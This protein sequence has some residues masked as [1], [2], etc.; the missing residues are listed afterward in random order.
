MPAET[1]QGRFR[2]E[3][4]KID[5]TPASAVSAGDVVVQT[6]L[7]GVASVDIAASA[8]GTLQ[9]AGV[10][11][12]VKV[13]GTIAAGVAVYWDADGDPLGGTSG[14]G[15]C[16]ATSTSNTFIGF[17]VSAAAD[18]AQFAVVYMVPAVS[19]TASNAASFAIADPGDAGAIPITGSGSVA[20]VSAAAETRTLADPAAAG[21]ILNIY[22]K[23]DVDD[24]TLT[25]ASPMNQTGNN[26]WVCA[27]T[28]D[29]LVLISVEDGADF[30]WRVLAED[31]GTLS[32]V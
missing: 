13:T 20:L 1:F 18:A 27:D 3:G 21:F 22:F 30:E 16:T 6:S 11:E 8:Q 15:C 26:T 19:V 17:V 10:V 14:T 29:N 28:G 31:G 25:S 7:V 12:I 32:T 4:T 9:V 2:Q 23:T 5:H 24:I